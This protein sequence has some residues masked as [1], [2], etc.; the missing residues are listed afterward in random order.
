[1]NVV[2]AA[3]TSDGLG[4]TLLR[5]ASVMVIEDNECDIVDVAMVIREKAAF[6]ARAIAVVLNESS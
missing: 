6:D 3:Q 4:L 2:V 5:L 1:M